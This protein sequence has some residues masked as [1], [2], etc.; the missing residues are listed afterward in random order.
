MLNHYAAHP[1]EVVV[2]AAATGAERKRYALGGRDGKT[3]VYPEDTMTDLQLKIFAATDIPPYRQHLSYSTGDLHSAHFYRVAVEGIAVPI[4]VAEMVASGESPDAARNDLAD[5][6]LDANMEEKH[7]DIVVTALDV[8][9]EVSTGIFIRSVS[10]VDLAEVTA[11]VD[12]AALADR[13]QF[14]RLYYTVI[15]YWPQLS[16]D[17]FRLA[18]SGGAAADIAAV[19][20]RLAPER[21]A[22]LARLDAERAAADRVHCTPGKCATSHHTTAVTSAAV[23]R[24]GHARVAVRN[25]FDWV[26]LGDEFLAASLRFEVYNSNNLV[27]PVIATK[28]R[29]QSSATKGG[30]PALAWFLA[31][32]PTANAAHYALAPATVS[33]RV[34]PTAAYAYISETGEFSVETWWREDDRVGFEA[35]AAHIAAASRPLVRAVN[36]MGAVALPLGGKLSSSSNKEESRFGAITASAYWGVAVTSAGFR[37]LKEQWRSYER[38]GIISIKGL[39]SG[40]SFAFLFRKGIPL[41]PGGPPVVASRGTP[42]SAPTNAFAYLTDGDPP[43]WGRAVLIHHRA[44]DL[45]V[46][47]VGA[48]GLAEFEMIRAYVFALLEH[49]RRVVAADYHDNLRAST[50]DA[51]HGPGTRRLRRLQE[52]DPALF[53]LKKHDNNATVYS[54][55]CQ[56]GRQP[57]VYSDAERALLPAGRRAKLVPYWNF[58]E[59]VPAFYECPSA[60]YP[61]LSFRSGKHPLGYC[62]PCCKKTAPPTPSRAA[63]INAACIAPYTGAA[64]N[65][66][67]NESAPGTILPLSSDV[68]LAAT[69]HVLSYG[70]P[71]PVGRV[72]EI[73]PMV[74]NGLLESKN[75][76]VAASFTG[77]PPAG[78]PDE[79]MLCAI[80]VP[81]S[82]AHVAAAGLMYA[83]AA[84][85]GTNVAGVVAEMARYLAGGVDGGVKGGRAP[86]GVAA[87]MARYLAGG[88]DGGTSYR[89]LGAGAG[90]AFVS[91]KALA[92]AIVNA[93][94]RGGVAQ[95][96]GAVIASLAQRCYGFMIV[97]LVDAAGTGDVIIE[98]DS[99]D[100][101]LPLLLLAV[102]PAG[103]Y[104]VF[105]INPREYLRTAVAARAR[106]AAVRLFPPAHA[107]AARLRAALARPAATHR[108]VDAALMA[109]FGR[110][111]GAQFR[112]LVNARDLCY[113][114][115]RE[116][117]RDRFVFLPVALGRVGGRGVSTAYGPRPRGAYPRADL[118]AAVAALNAHILK[119]DP[120]YDPV[121]P[122]A[123]LV[124]AAGADIG[125]EAGGL[126]YWADAGGGGGPPLTPPATSTMLG[127]PPVDDLKTI[128]VPYDPLDVDEALWKAGEQNRASA[129]FTGAPVKLVLKL[130]PAALSANRLYRLFEAEFVAALRREK[131]TAVRAAIA[132]VFTSPPD[133]AARLAALAD[134]ERNHTIGPADAATLRAAPAFDADASYE[135][136]R[137]TLTRLRLLAKNTGHDAA[138]A[139]VRE[140]MKPHV[141]LVSTDLKSDGTDVSAGNLF[142]A[143]SLE[144]S[145]TRKH[146]DGPRLRVPEDRF[147]DLADI[148]ASDINN[149]YKANEIALSAAGVFDETRFIERPNE[150]LS[151]SQ[152]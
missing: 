150:I 141:S 35:V 137:V 4:D 16:P 123:R 134:M 32:P 6:V 74:A 145:V 25:V 66:S 98:C 60:A 152:I 64:R 97:R 96:S 104:P 81:Q 93:Y 138:A 102:S 29:V 114:V 8:K 103:T 57:H 105:A 146:C 82:T 124:N 14:D 115:L 135:F 89:T 139:A 17:A 144:T 52:R 7:L 117:A 121:V 22:V 70:K 151:V 41:P 33:D 42:S 31:H 110:A 106:A 54:V 147:N 100:G 127:G 23:I 65:D 83:I 116:V 5:L 34:N 131:N 15:K 91:A 140:F 67:R 3:M 95:I 87:E 53:D 51:L 75:V 122:S 11:L 129:S 48:Q 36:A 68:S 45:R 10:V 58:T 30:A 73:A 142:A 143:C 133:R 27:V 79:V 47:V 59:K 136:D 24:P 13:L 101:S 126:R 111:S 12:R 130:A 118:D 76:S 90:A 55:L 9:M 19:Y 2:R 40:G 28:Q 85:V 39:Q 132:G 44:T 112:Y 72:S 63:A 38:A 71:V 1:L 86:P 119:C 43:A 125:F 92:D 99:T 94:V 128:R 149:P 108:P 21:A 37:E 61:F 80:G 49:V 56:A 62:L 120:D 18:C 113:G 46:E 50:D 148:L 20:P 84:A 109:K 107:V 78:T 26:A 88:V 69:R 77:T